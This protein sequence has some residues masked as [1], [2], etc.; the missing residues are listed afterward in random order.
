MEFQTMHKTKLL[1]QIFKV[2]S[3]ILRGG[4][5]K[6]PHRLPR[7][8]HR[9]ICVFIDALKKLFTRIYSSFLPLCYPSLSLQV[10]G[11]LQNKEEVYQAAKIA[12]PNVTAFAYFSS[13]INPILYVFAGSSHIRQAGLNF[14]GKLF[15]ATNSETRTSTT[16]GSSSRDEN[17]VLYSLSVKMGRPFKGKNKER[18]ISVA[19]K[20]NNDPTL[21]TLATVE[22]FD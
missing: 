6:K 17:T 11:L 21:N 14:M 5:K 19:D 1:Q 20:E 12:R 3:G 9:L 4:V 2:F 7:N 22:Q 10:V 8:L 16:R 18:S 13:A 15:E